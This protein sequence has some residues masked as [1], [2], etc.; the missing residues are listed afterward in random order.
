M[1]E[2]YY[3]GDTDKNFQPTN[4]E[5]GVIDQLE[6]FGLEEEDLSGDILDIG[7]G[8]ANFARYF[9][10][11]DDLKIT[12][13]D[14]D[15][16]DESVE[17]IKADA[18]DLPFADDSFNHVLSHASIPNV[19]V[20]FYISEDPEHSKEE[21]SSAVNKSITEIVRV[22]KE[23]GE[24]RLAPVV[25]AKNYDSQLALTNSVLETVEMLK[26]KEGLDISFEFI[27]TRTNPKNLEKSDEYRLIIKKK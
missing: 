5:E 24:A 14:L 18:R 26:K 3:R 6:T 1:S 27:T 2:K 4:I 10:D 22:L 16:E 19:F 15:P 13:I 7:A 21:I 12:S 20:S 23:G 9:K 17:V 8:D 25:I 11:R